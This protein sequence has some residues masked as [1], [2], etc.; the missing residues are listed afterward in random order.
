MT[1][2]DMH[3]HLKYRSRCSNLSAEDLNENI[4]QKLDGICLTDHW[5]IKEK[6]TN[7]FSDHIKIFYGV[8]M[9]CMLG[10]ILGYGFQLFPCGKEISQLI[11]S[12]NLFIAEG[13]SR[14]A[15][16]LFPIDMRDLVNMYMTMILMP[17]K[18]MGP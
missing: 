10:D 3:V 14:Y 9:D 7:P 6:Q 15:P 12:L 18:S 5:L 2:I 17:S 8:E 4:S 1:I 16:I 13:A 11:I